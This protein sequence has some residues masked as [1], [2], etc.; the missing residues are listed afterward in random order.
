VVLALSVSCL[1]SRHLQRSVDNASGKW[2]DDSSIESN[3]ALTSIYHPDAISIRLFSHEVFLCLHFVFYCV[4][5]MADK[6]VCKPEQESCD[7]RV[8]TFS[9]PLNPLFVMNCH[10][11]NL[12]NNIKNMSLAVCCGY[13][14]LIG[15]FFF[16][17]LTYMAWTRNVVFLEHKA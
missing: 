17:V 5:W 13:L 4:E 6:A 2:W 3:Y 8:Q 10:F 1:I 14:S 12:Y 11:V 7:Q 16:L 15:V 9:V